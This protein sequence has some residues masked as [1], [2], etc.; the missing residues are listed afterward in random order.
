MLVW[1]LILLTN[2]TSEEKYIDWKLQSVKHKL[3]IFCI[4]ASELCRQKS[5][6]VIMTF[7]ECSKFSLFSISA[8]FKDCDRR[9]R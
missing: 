2:I 9:L 6:I 5:K 4:S 8:F 3:V 1:I 7:H